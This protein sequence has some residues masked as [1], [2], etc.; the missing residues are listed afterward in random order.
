MSMKLI[1]RFAKL[2]NSIL[3]KFGLRVVRAASIK[4][5]ENPSWKASTVPLGRFERE[6]YLEEGEFQYI[7]W[8]DRVYQK[9][10]RVPGHIVEFGVAYGRNAVLF[11]R[12]INMAGES[13]TRRYFGF[14]TFSGYTDGTLGSNP[15]L[16]AKSW[17]DCD[18][19]AV[20]QRLVRAGVAQQTQLIEGDL[21]KTVPQ[22]L[23]ET[24]NF[25]CALLYVDCNAYEPALEGMQMMRPYMSPGGVVC[26]DEKLQGGETK[27]LIE[28]CAKNNLEF[29]RDPGPFS[30]P[31]YTRIPQ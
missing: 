27:A 23:S 28:F 19:E 22:F 29:V 15:Q 7:L 16:S 4:V 30:V 24:P 25:R 26:I 1:S 5:L 31:A 9:I 13:K 18:K 10:A 3:G 6:V 2:L 21:V 20:D 11:G 12:M 14:D 8:I 17:M